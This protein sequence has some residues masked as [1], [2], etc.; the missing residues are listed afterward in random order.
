MDEQNERMDRFDRDLKLI[1]T[2]VQRTLVDLRSLVMDADSPLGDR[3]D[4]DVLEEALTKAA[5]WQFE[6]DA[7]DTI[8]DSYRSTERSDGSSPT[9]LSDETPIAGPDRTTALQE[10]V[11]ELREE[12]KL[13]ALERVAEGKQAP[14]HKNSDSKGEGTDSNRTEGVGRSL[15][16]RP[17]R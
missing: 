7:A 2:E 4:P 12:L 17:R 3:F 15:G 16:A 1:R 14:V 13:F 5:P 8:E 11:R 6:A 9:Y 10:E